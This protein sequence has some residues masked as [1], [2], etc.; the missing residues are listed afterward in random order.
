MGSADRARPAAALL[1]PPPPPLSPPAVAPPP[2]APPPLAPPPVAPPPS[3]RGEGGARRRAA[4]PPLPTAR[5]V[6][7][8]ESEPSLRQ[9]GS[10]YHRFSM[11]QRPLLPQEMPK[12]EREK[13]L[14]QRWRAL[15]E[16]KR[17]RYKAA[18]QAR[19]IPRHPPSPYTGAVTP[20]PHPNRSPPPLNPP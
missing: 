8:K 4:P 17:A 3:V 19:P 5:P 20:D 12:G 10:A 1:P 9:T 16:A 6:P 2:L 15:P 7:V 18:G 11:E 13:L 14:G